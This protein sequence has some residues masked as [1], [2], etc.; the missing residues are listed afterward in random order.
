MT[1]I[2]DLYVTLRTISAPAVEGFAATA[3]AGEEMA[4]QVLTSSEEV[5]LATERMSASVRAFAVAVDEMALQASI[6][7]QKMAA[8]TAEASLKMEVA[9]ARAAASTAAVGEAMTATA[10]KSAGLVG[11]LALTAAGFGL[12]GLGTV[13]M[14]GDFESSTNRLVTSAGETRDNLDMVRQGMLQMTG[15]VGDGAEALAQAMYVIESGGQHGADGLMVLRAAAEGA[16]AENADLTVVADAVTSVLQDYHLKAE[17]AAMVTTKLVAAVGAGKTTFQDLSG[18]LHS[19]LPLA[20][21]LHISL[22][23]ITG[24]LASMTVHGMSADQAAQNL[25]DTIKHMAAPTGVQIAELGQLGISVSGLTDMMGE[26]G[27]TG[28]LQY[29]SETIL[30]HMGP[31]GRVLLDSFNQSRDAANDANTMILAMPG[32]L[33]DLARGFQNGSITLADWRKDLKGLP[34]DQANLLEQFAT[35]QDR[36]AGF[37]N[38]LKSGGPAAQ[39]YQDALRRVTGDATGLNVAL[40]LTGENTAYVNNAV[41][42]VASAT[43]EAGN[44]VKGWSDIQDTFNQ[45]MS[46]AKDGLGGLAIEVGQNLLPAVSDFVGVLADG[47]KWLSQHQTLATALAVAL[48]VL[49]VGF[50]VAAVAV[51]VMNSALLANP[52]TWIILA[53]VVAIAIM[54]ASIWYMVT[55]FQ[56]A[57]DTVKK[58][59]KVVWDWLVDA[60]HWTLDK[61]AEGAAWIHDNVIQPIV[62]FFDKYLV[63]PIRAYLRIVTAVWEFAWGFLS[64]IIDDFVK[65]WH[66]VWGAITS[67]AQW[68][69]DNVLKP[70][71]DFIIKYGVDPIKAGIHLLAEGW[72][73]AWDW[74]SSRA[75]EA[76][77]NLKI[78]FGFVDQY[79]I[80]PVHAAISWFADEWDTIWNAIAST[81]D[82]IYNTYIKPIFDKIAGSISSVKSGVSGFLNA[83]GDAGRAFAHMLGFD[84]GGWVPGTPGAPIP[85][86]VH[87]GEFVVSR[88]M[89][90]GRQAMPFQLGGPVGAGSPA[91]SVIENRVHV[92]IDGDEIQ[93]ATMRSA[94]RNKLRNGTNG[95]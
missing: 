24:A 33:Q 38:V 81:V 75:S 51:W 78:V 53:F 19:V 45:K 15:E 17:D 3:K 84:E 28:T 50:T 1:E 67:R 5:T 89:L 36:A 68:A 73:I 54:V 74:I 18:S 25:N 83:P 34:V 7:Y 88:D 79:G 16:K 26:K 37:N 42:T 10:G 92:Y 64:V 20:S 35:L 29:L 56:A 85:A 9:Q 8:Q 65:V 22:E 77:D 55:H 49:T 43:T 23:D 12:I 70:I 44:H 95:F 47:A 60:W 58:I 69:W 90:A 63:E 72:S 2:S 41:Q 87:G 59:A 86:V 46:E 71:L 48:G 40:M 93:T 94:G 27:I 30:D 91:R 76:W 82:N 14:A 62:N 57:W 31:S 39:T 52:I 13:K 66:T 6:D 11:P 4:A 61:L 32:P 21:N 80:Q